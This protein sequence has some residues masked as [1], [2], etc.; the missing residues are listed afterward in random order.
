MAGNH[1]HHKVAASVQRPRQGLG[2]S[3]ATLPLLGPWGPG[4]AGQDCA[5]YTLALSFMH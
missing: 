1:L 4:S 2:T 5:C 3:L